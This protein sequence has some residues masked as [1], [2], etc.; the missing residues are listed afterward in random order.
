[1]PGL[2]L[3]RLAERTPIKITISVSPDL[4]N[5]LS[6]YAAL[7]ASTYGRDEPVTELIPAMV[8]AFIE[9]D[10]GFAQA[11]KRAPAGSK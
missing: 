8:A 3:A 1:M 7:Y 5:A 4:N 6:D 10:R 9:S 2:K 11:R